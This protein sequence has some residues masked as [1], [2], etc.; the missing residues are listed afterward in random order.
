MTDTWPP[1]NHLSTQY[2]H[3]EGHYK[4]QKGR[5]VYSS[6][7]IF[8]LDVSMHAQETRHFHLLCSLQPI[9]TVVSSL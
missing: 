7:F 5:L 9:L 1:G 6:V 8:R 2:R 4:G 3:P